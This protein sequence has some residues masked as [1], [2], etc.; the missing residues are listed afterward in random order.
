MDPKKAKYGED[1]YKNIAKQSWKNKNRNRRVG[2]AAMDPERHKEVSS[3]GGKTKKEK[4][5]TDE[6]VGEE[7]MDSILEVDS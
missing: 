2:F 1:Y 6:Q 5:I 3:K 7:G 4:I